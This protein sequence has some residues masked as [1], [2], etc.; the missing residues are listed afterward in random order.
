MEK[1]ATMTPRPTEQRKARSVC[2]AKSLNFPLKRS[3]TAVMLNDFKA[4]ISLSKIP[5]MRAIV[6]PDT[7]GITLAEPIPMPLKKFAICCFILTVFT[8]I[9]N[10]IFF[11]EVHD[12]LVGG[13][14]F[15]IEI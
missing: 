4:L 2:R 5:V 6:P 12:R 15:R 13:K 3:F 7:P 11:N 1:I 8:L 14:V 9:L 10:P